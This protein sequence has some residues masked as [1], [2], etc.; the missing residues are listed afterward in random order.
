M[1][2]SQYYRWAVLVWFLSLVGC[3]TTAVPVAVENPTETWHQYLQQMYAVDRWEVKGKLA[4][5]TNKRGEQINML[6]N[7]NEA[8]H[9]INLYG[10]LG[11]GNVI[12]TSDAEGATLRDNKKKTYHDN[13]T[14]ELLYRVAGWRVPFAEMQY[15]ILGIPSPESKHSFQL[16]NI[17]R[18]GTLEQNGWRIEFL[19]Y[20]IVDGRALPRKLDIQALPG[21]KHIVQDEH[22]EN[23]TIRIKALIKRWRALGN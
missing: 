2:N 8:D 1:I 7:R 21:S 11:L 9:D 16:D 23:D 13:S 18:L 20:R 4:V 17:G 12:L 15:W 6:W 5:R 19:E 3:V 10:P 22:G 14:E